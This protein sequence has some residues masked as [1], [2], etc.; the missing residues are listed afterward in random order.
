KGLKVVIKEWSGRTF[1]ELE[2]TKK[3]L[4]DEIGVLDLKS[5]ALGLVEGEVIRRKKLF[6][7]LW[8][9]LK[10]ID[11]MTFQRSRSRWLK[12]GDTNSKYFHNCVKIRSRRNKLVALRTTNGWV[13]G[14]SLVREEVLA[15]FRKHFD[16]DVWHRPTLDGIEFPCLSQARVDDLTAIFT[17]EEIST[18]VKECDGDKSPGPD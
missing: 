17:M 11:A 6:E 16:N 13:D 15:Y 10:N 8:I 12:E 18:V 5:E 3:R 9:I 2:Q 1:G 14:P 4:I 7:E